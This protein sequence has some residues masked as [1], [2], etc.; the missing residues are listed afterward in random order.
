MSINWNNL[1]PWNGSQQSAFEELCCQLASYEEMPENSIFIRKG[2]PDAGV[3]CF[4]KLPDGKENG[5]Q[6]KYFLSPPD[7]AQWKQ[8]DNS[9]Q[10][11]ID[12]HPQ[13][14][15]YMVCLPI[16]RPDARIGGQKSCLEKW[17]DHVEKWKRWAV[18]KKM[19]VEFIYWGESEIFQRLSQEKHRGRYLFWFN[20]DMLTYQKMLNQID[21]T[22]VNVG[23]RYTPEL[24]VHLELSEMFEFIARTDRYVLE[25]RKNIGLVRRKA[26]NINPKDAE[27]YLREHINK[28]ITLVDE[29]LKQI[30]RFTYSAIEFVDL[31]SLS[32]LS[33]NFK[34]LHWECEKTIHQA[35]TDEFVAKH[36]KKPEEMPHYY[37]SEKHDRWLSS[38]RY[39]R[40][41][42]DNLYVYIEGDNAQLAITPAMLLSG[43]AGSGKTHLLCD[44]SKERINQG[45]PTVL[46]LGQNFYEGDVWEQI[47]KQLHINCATKDELLGILNTAGQASGARALLLIDAINESVSKKLWKN[48]LAGM[49]HSLSQYPWVGIVLSIRNTYFEYM[50]PQQLIE[51]RKL[52]VVS[53]KGFAG[54][55]YKA[56]RE[57]FRYYSIKQ[58]D[59]PLL[60]PE[61]QNPLFLKLFCRGLNNAGIIEV[62]RG[63]QNI[64]KVYENFIESVNNK[65]SNE[66]I[67]NYDP[68]DKIVWKAVEELAGKMAERNDSRI[69]LTEAKDIVHKIL[70]PK[71]YHN[72]L[73]HHLETEGIITESIVYTKDTCEEA[74]QFSYERFA[75]HLIAKYL[76]NKHLNVDTPELSFKN[77]QPLA[78][79]FTPEFY[80]HYEGLIEAVSIQ[81][82]E[83]IGKEL[84]ELVPQYA[85]RNSVRQ[86]FLNSLIW[87]D[88]KT[89]NKKTKDIINEHIIQNNYDQLMETF[90]T[91]ATLKD[92]PFNA[93]ALH[94]YLLKHDLPNRDA[95]WS[96]FLFYQIE[97]NGAVDRLIDWAWSPEDKSHIEDSSILLTAKTLAWFLTTPQRFLRDRATK[98]MVNLLTNRIEL[99]PKLIEDFKTADDPYVH[100]RLYGVAYGCAMRTTEKNKICILADYIYENIFKNDAPPVDV[101]LRDYAR[102]VIELSLHYGLKTTA[103][104]KKI[105]PPY[106]STWPNDIPS[107]DELENVYSYKAEKKGI[108]VDEHL[109]RLYHHIA[110]SGSSDFNRYIIN[111]VCYGWSSRR[112][113]EPKKITNKERYD[114][115]VESLTIQQKKAWDKLCECRTL[116]FRI[117]LSNLGDKASDIKSSEAEKRLDEAENNFIKILKKKKRLQYSE[118]VVP[119]LNNK[120]PQDEHFDKSIA[121]SFIFKR[122]LDLGWS[123]KLHAEFDENRHDMGRRA[124]KPERI[125]KKY[126]WIAYHELLARLCDNF[127]YKEDSWSGDKSYEGPWQD[128]ARDIDPSYVLSGSE[129]EH[130][131]NSHRKCWWFPLS[132]DLWHTEENPSGWLQKT[133]DLPSS[134]KVIEVKA[135]DDSVWLSLEGFYHFREP[136]PPEEETYEKERREIWYMIKSYLVKKSDI[137]TFYNWAKTKDFFGRW[138]PE[139]HENTRIFIGEFFWSPAFNFHNKPYYNHDG[140]TKGRKG[141]HEIPVPVLVTTDGYLQESGC[142]DCSVREN[143][144]LYLP[145]KT[146]VDEM[147]LCWNGREGEWY[148][149]NNNLVTF[150]PSLRV[151]G[152]GCLL[153]SKDTFRE[154]LDKK[155]YD[156]L[157]TILG[158]KN[159]IGGSMRHEDWKGRLYIN[160][161]ARF[162]NERLITN[163]HYNFEKPN[164]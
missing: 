154:Y 104:L 122:V 59:V 29:L 81:L 123:S 133:S 64:T 113:G 108:K 72:S 82:P 116:V 58:P 88:P 12:K 162:E 39:L 6:A 160:G 2:S 121:E 125:G 8:I 53:H 92:H 151:K 65:L 107:K 89:I 112:K 85:K 103:C 69:P 76:L 161:V 120:I 62:P 118:F 49:L 30:T 48:N 110:D 153:I 164:K 44:I 90:I 60:N 57:F 45:L 147:S 84:I 163:V 157:W 111:H 17:N 37:P 71:G 51:E 146:I 43:S 25:L 52:I 117:T 142:Y 155:G 32:D 54:I 139:S 93:D 102:G 35:K 3:E 47:I 23:P 9:I 1:R 95:T 130:W 87:R 19:Q 11:A 83:R 41:A 101:L 34:E 134:S 36:N 149:P 159:M 96:K 70:P 66:N 137:D 42:I 28:L 38:I 148:N 75:D 31:S 158:E 16:N 77:G 141:E 115:F 55:E 15:N 63:S 136:V 33:K 129:R 61:F 24:N 132:Y 126:Q 114:S 138:M 67:L 94:Q 119:Y 100:E 144:N 127:E 74:I 20:S 80:W 21:E 27:Q 105:R 131:M 140:W 14:S 10:N 50:I 86:A 73:F 18:G 22:I 68:R 145:T 13:L 135:E 78:N 143:V 56:T 99:L 156:I 152:P 150:D 106:K 5:W 128:F 79:L 124:D 91:I 40:E 98:A 7:N 26:S 4:W 109:R 97:E 46:L